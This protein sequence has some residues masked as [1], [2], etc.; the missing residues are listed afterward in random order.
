MPFN[1]DGTLRFSC[2]VIQQLVPLCNATAGFCTLSCPSWRGLTDSQSGGQILQI[3][4]MRQ[5][6]SSR[7]LACL[8]H[9]VQ[10]AISEAYV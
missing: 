4:Q 5:L 6:L 2:G 9:Q 3:A 10:G 8:L 1:K 7:D